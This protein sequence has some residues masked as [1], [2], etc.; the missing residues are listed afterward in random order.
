MVEE[1][2]LDIILTSDIAAKETNLA[3]TEKSQSME[4][5]ILHSV[6]GIELLEKY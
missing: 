2:K 4:H 6:L 1:S 5:E 3:H